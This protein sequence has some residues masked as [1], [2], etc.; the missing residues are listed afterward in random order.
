[1]EIGKTLF[2]DSSKK[3]LCLYITKRRDWR[4][5]L[6]KNHYKEAEIWLISYRKATG[7][8]N[9][10]YNDAVEEALCFGWIDSMVKKLDDERSAQRFT[11]R[12]PKSTWSKMNKVRAR[13]LI[14]EGKMT[15]A[16]LAKLQNI[17]NSFVIPT[18]ILKA[19]K[20]NK[21]VWNNFRNFPDSYKRIRIGWIDGA[22]KRP[23]EFKKRLDYFLKMTAKNQ[24]FGMVR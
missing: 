21:T 22:R 12:N 4:K 11:P 6:E 14:T 23:E 20:S 10:P 8:P 9:L 2:R 3:M 16:G 7:K 19:L 15:K 17:H 5:W 1:M 18:N 24:K 13:R